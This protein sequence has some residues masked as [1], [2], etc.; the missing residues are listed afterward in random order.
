MIRFLPGI[1]IIFI[2]L[3]TT[4]MLVVTRCEQQPQKSLVPIETTT[5]FTVEIE[6]RDVAR[7]MSRVVECLRHEHHA[8]QTSSTAC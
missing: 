5:R 6:D 7:K 8:Q 4:I 2:S 1:A 3:V